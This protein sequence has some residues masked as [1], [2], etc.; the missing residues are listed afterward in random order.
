MNVFSGPRLKRHMCMECRR[1][2]TPTMWFKTQQS[3]NPTTQQPSNSTINLLLYCSEP[4]N[5]LHF[6]FEASRVNWTTGC[7]FFGSR[8]ASSRSSGTKD[9]H[10]LLKTTYPGTELIST[11]TFCQILIVCTDRGHVFGRLYLNFFDVIQRELKTCKVNRWNVWIDLPISDSGRDNMFGFHPPVRV[12]FWSRV[13]WQV[14]ATR[15]R[16][17][18]ALGFE[19]G[20]HLSGRDQ[21]EDNNGLTRKLRHVALANVCRDFLV[22][23]RFPRRRINRTCWNKSYQGS[24]PFENISYRSIPKAQTSDLMENNASRWSDSGAILNYTMSTWNT[25][26][27]YHLSGICCLPPTSGS[28]SAIG[29]LRPKSA[30]LII[31]YALIRQFRVARSRCTISLNQ[32]LHSHYDPTRTHLW[33]CR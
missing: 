6:V 12:W 13:S 11:Y 19:V 16:S 8:R 10:R 5:G 29:L 15:C 32:E 2:S 28:N 1:H 20:C 17:L 9:H 22:L 24:A 25:V 4:V 14:R 30:I 27:P 3:N 31:P 26:E 33:W 21:L 18:R 7:D 23:P